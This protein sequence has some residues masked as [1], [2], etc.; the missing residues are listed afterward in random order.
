MFCIF[1]FNG[2]WRL[3]HCYSHLVSF[4][5]EPFIVSLTSM[6]FYDFSS[7]S[8]LSDNY[9]QG[10]RV[11][12]LFL[13][14]W[15]PFTVSSF[16]RLLFL[17]ILFS[18][19]ELY[20]VVRLFEDKNADSVINANVTRFLCKWLTLLKGIRREL[21]FERLKPSPFVKKKSQKFCSCLIKA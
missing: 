2:F 4:R 9:Y 14:L 12:C 19:Y 13:C 8:L 10:N 3:D 5:I 1:D 6:L 18:R 17:K 21:A 7:S 20:R 16:S 11:P 15:E